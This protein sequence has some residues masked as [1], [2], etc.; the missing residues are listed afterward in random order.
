LN[1]KGDTFR[2]V[3]PK[4]RD[5]YDDIFAPRPQKKFNPN[6]QYPCEECPQEET[7]GHSCTALALFQ[8]REKRRKGHNSK[9]TAHNGIW[10]DIVENTNPDA[11]NPT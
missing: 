5:N 1:G 11:I 7:C 2:R 6:P 8:Y 3:G 10:V 9:T 4:Y